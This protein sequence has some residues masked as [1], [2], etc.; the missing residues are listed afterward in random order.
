VSVTLHTLFFLEI[1]STKI[2]TSRLFNP[3]QCVR[4]YKNQPAAQSRI[5]ISVNRKK[6]LRF[7][8]LSNPFQSANCGLSQHGTPR[9]LILYDR[10]C[11]TL[12]VFFTSQ[13]KNPSSYYLSFINSKQRNMI[14]HCRR[15]Q[16]SNSRRLDCSLDFYDDEDLMPR[17]LHRPMTPTRHENSDL[18]ESLCMEAESEDWATMC[19]YYPTIRRGSLQQS[20]L[21]KE[22]ASISRP[23]SHQRRHSSY[24][25]RDRATHRDEHHLLK[26]HLLTR[27]TDPLREERSILIDNLYELKSSL[28]LLE[29]LPETTLNSS[30]PSIPSYPILK[31][32]LDFDDDDDDSI[33]L[34]QSKQKNLESLSRQHDS[35]EFLSDVF[36]TLQPSVDNNTT[37]VEY[38]MDLPPVIEEEKS[39]TKRRRRKVPSYQILQKQMESQS[40]STLVKSMLRTRQDNSMH[41]PESTTTTTS[42]TLS[43]SKACSDINNNTKR[44]FPM[45]NSQT[46]LTQIQYARG[47]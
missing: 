29:G 20:F 26:E 19:R 7:I 43:Q 34:A 23:K 8:D 30:E 12:F 17:M 44:S 27:D 45:S 40:I 3:I 33:D 9:I 21:T 10:L 39:I 38:V 28:R 24:N 11:H 16:E 18:L 31:Y 5:L 36:D 25:T 47:A 35:D 14:D 32:M 46:M 15:Y 2:V 22:V 42:Q 4:A 6:T 41:S 1:Y 13:N 37:Y